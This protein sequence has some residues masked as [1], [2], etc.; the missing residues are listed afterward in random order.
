MPVSY[1]HVGLCVSD[2]D[3]S[4]RFY[5]DGLGFEVDRRVDVDARFTSALEVDEPAD[6]T[7]QYLR[8]DGVLIELLALRRPRAHGAPSASRGA[9]GL[10]HLSFV[11]DDVDTVAA[12][13]VELGGSVL[14][15]TRLRYDVGSGESELVFLADPDGIRVELLRRPTSA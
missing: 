6:V 12:R 14:E 3:R 5:R 13:L 8:K 1:S 10:T 4:L 2:L 7:A 11:V 9:L 15:S